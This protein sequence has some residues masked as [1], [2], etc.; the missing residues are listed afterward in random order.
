MTFNPDFKV[1]TFFIDTMSR[2]NVIVVKSVW[3]ILL[4]SSYC[5]HCAKCKAVLFLLT[6][7]FSAFR[8]AWATL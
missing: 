6:V 3:V 7:D 1:T 8:P 2:D 5:Q 4:I